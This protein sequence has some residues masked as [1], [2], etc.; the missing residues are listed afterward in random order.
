MARKFKLIE[1]HKFRQS[2]QAYV[3]TDGFH[4]GRFFADVGPDRL[5]NQDYTALTKAVLEKMVEQAAVTWIKY[6]KVKLEG[7]DRWSN[8]PSTGYFEL[9][10]DRRQAALMPNGHWTTAK[11]DDPEPLRNTMTEDKVDFN[12]L[13]VSHFDDWHDDENIPTHF[14]P[15]DDATWNMLVWMGNELNR[16]RELLEQM[17]SSVEGR[18]QLATTA[19]AAGPLMITGGE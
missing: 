18:K 16:F 6:I 19:K 13:P 5:T 4:I 3:E 10:Y 8:Q 9:D 1:H 11:F 14:L 7:G 17:I 15:Y 12:N 2:V